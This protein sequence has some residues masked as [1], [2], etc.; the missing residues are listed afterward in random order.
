RAVGR[1]GVGVYASSP[2]DLVVGPDHHIFA[3]DR[4]LATYEGTDG[5]LLDL[6]A[7]VMGPEIELPRP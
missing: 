5:A 1:Y 2:P 7:E 4:V 3:V 6:L